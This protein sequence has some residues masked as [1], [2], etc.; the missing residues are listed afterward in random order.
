[1]FPT[2][3]IPA[4]DSSPFPPEAVTLLLHF[5]GAPNDTVT[6]DSSTYAREIALIASKLEATGVFSS[7]TYWVP[8]GQF[9]RAVVI[10]YGDGGF[11]VSDSD[12]C[13]E[14][15]IN[16][17]SGDFG[18]G[19]LFSVGYPSTSDRLEVV[20]LSGTTLTVRSY[21]ANVLEWSITG[22]FT[23]DTWQHVAL[24]RHNGDVKLYIQGVLQATQVAAEL[25]TEPTPQFG[26][27]LNL[28]GGFEYWNGAIDEVRFVQ[29]YPVYTDEFDPPTE[30]F[31]DP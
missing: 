11:N 31:P 19:N 26:V 3:F 8:T 21:V 14:C 2:F 24:V 10:D 28:G 6:V 9:A 30:P 1:M 27:S 5:D 12:W 23:A 20:L 18:G 17:G 7:G 25:T 15:W 13:M 29:G 22:T 16:H 4:A